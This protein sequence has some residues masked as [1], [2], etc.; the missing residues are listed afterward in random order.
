M[1]DKPYDFDPVEFFGEIPG[2]DVPEDKPYDLVDGIAWQ[3]PPILNIQGGDDPEANVIR[4]DA[5]VRLR[6]VCRGGHEHRFRLTAW[7][8]NVVKG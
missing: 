7:L 2:I 4:I 8:C 6:W 3:P 5:A 1:S